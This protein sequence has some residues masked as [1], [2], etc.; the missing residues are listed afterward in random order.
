MV[1]KTDVEDLGLLSLR[2]EAFPVSARSFEEP[3]L[4]RSLEQLSV[5][6]RFLEVISEFGQPFAE[7]QEMDDDLLEILSKGKGFVFSSFH[8]LFK[9]PHTMILAVPQVFSEEC[10]WNDG[11]YN[12]S[13][14]TAGEVRVPLAAMREEPIF[15]RDTDFCG[16]LCGFPDLR[17]GALAELGL[18]KEAQLLVLQE[19]LGPEM[20]EDLGVLLQF[21]SDFRAV[22]PFNPSTRFYRP[23]E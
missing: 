9:P 7:D 18:Q 21:A 15:R 1:Q 20:S 19:G 11:E 6:A 13:K 22:D 4:P 12:I 5:P 17:P 3:L 23:G 2:G 14:M 10:Y 8:F 16:L